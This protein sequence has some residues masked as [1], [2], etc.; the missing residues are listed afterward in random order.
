MEDVSFE[1]MWLVY[2]KGDEQKDTGLRFIPLDEEDVLF[3]CPEC[4]QEVKAPIPEEIE[5]G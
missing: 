4:N 2:K 5:W 3:K 1:G